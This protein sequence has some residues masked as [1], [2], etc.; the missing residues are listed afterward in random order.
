MGDRKS[1]QSNLFGNCFRYFQGGGGKNLS[2]CK[3]AAK[4]KTIPTSSFP[5]KPTVC[6]VITK[7]E[8]GFY[9]E[10]YLW[11]LLQKQK[12]VS[13]WGIWSCI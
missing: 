12:H 6:T 10:S 2:G 3:L 11:I 5:P 9:L 4:F 13:V 1:E 7:V 8:V